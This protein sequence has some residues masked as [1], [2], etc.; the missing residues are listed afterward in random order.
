MGQLRAAPPTG[1]FN[2]CFLVI[3]AIM[4]TK[5]HGS[6]LGFQTKN[7]TNR[8]WWTRWNAFG[9]VPLPF[10]VVD[11]LRRAYGRIL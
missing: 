11:E 5:Q 6:V 3:L 4:V 10:G 7:P 8:T 1:L 2:L 9:V